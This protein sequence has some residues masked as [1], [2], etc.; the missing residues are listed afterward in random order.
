MDLLCVGFDFAQPDK[1][2]II[3]LGKL[4]NYQIAT[5]SHLRIGILKVILVPSP[6]IELMKTRPLM[7]DIET[8]AVIIDNNA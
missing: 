4:S 8:F 5:L 6:G 1:P 7:F 3:R 2:V